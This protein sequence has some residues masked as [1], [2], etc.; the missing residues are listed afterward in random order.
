M[1]GAEEY[2][3]AIARSCGLNDLG[4]DEDVAPIPSCP[5]IGARLLVALAEKQHLSMSAVIVQYVIGLVQSTEQGQNALCPEDLV[6]GL[7]VRFGLGV[8]SVQHG[9]FAMG[10][11][12][13]KNRP[14]V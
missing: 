8:Q 3:Q 4:T 5:V 1:G 14:K 7:G 9:F 11:C 10:G 2:C 13:S 12:K 6:L